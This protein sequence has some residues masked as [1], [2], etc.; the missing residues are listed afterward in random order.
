VQRKN[1]F[2]SF[3]EL[4]RTFGS[5]D[6]VLNCLVFNIGGGKYRLVA[7][8]NFTAHRLWVKYILPHEAYEKLN[9]REDEKCQ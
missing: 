6:I 1:N 9:L 8:V 5:A 3:A 4:K 2:G 7:R